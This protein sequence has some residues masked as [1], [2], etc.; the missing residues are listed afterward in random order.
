MSEG[1]RWHAASVSVRQF[2]KEGIYCCPQPAP[3]RHRQEKRYALAEENDGCERR[4]KCPQ[5]R[6]SI[7][8][9]GRPHPM[10]QA[11]EAPQ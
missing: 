7:R 1:A 8:R 9:R 10:I 4:G 6:R 2:Q 3:E 5:K 11:T